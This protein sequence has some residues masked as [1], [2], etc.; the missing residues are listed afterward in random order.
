M[1]YKKILGCFFILLFS[2]QLVPV[3]NVGS[4]LYSNQMTEEI[5]HGSDDAPVKKMA[6]PCKQLHSF[7]PDFGDNVALTGDPITAKAT[8]E[9]IISRALDDI[10]TPPPNYY[11]IC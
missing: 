9:N 8:D 11:T 3:Q 4:F 7:N 5:P 10:Q 6:D 2:F 1:L